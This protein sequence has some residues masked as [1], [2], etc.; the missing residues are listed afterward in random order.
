MSSSTTLG[1]KR[2]AAQAVFSQGGVLGAIR[3]RLGM[4]WRARAPRHLRVAETVTLGERRI[5]ALVECGKQ[6]FLIGGSSATVV[7]LARLN[8]DSEEI[9][10]P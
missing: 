4:L 7:L 5:L 6:R 10:C 8:S 3:S 9:S 1:P 2:R